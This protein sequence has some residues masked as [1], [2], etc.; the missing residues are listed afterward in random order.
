MVAPDA[1][2]LGIDFG[3]R[4]VGLATGSLSSGL[5]SPWQTLQVRGRDHAI[6]QLVAILEPGE[7][8]LA[9]LGLPLAES[10][11]DTPAARRLRRIGEVISRRSGVDVVLQDEWASSLDA[12][13][14]LRDAGGR[15]SLDAASAAVI[16]QGYLDGVAP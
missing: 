11:D 4:R 14:R 5:A 2:I 8:A 16:L 12:A 9:V 3:G 13:A 1:R 10:G 7:F 6:D 15:A